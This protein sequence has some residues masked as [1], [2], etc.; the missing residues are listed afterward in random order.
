M[1]S[2]GHLGLHG[3]LPRMVFPRVRCWIV[4]IFT[5]IYTSVIGLLPTATSMLGHLYAGDIQAYLN[6]F[7]S[8]STAAVLVMSSDFE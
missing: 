7:A 6:F 8:S 2:M 4:P 5:I 1:W 3:A